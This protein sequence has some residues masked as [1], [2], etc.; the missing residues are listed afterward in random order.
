MGI[1]SR[2]FKGGQD[3]EPPDDDPEVDRIEAHAVEAV[4]VAPPSAPVAAPPAVKHAVGSEPTS[5]PKIEPGMW[6]WP[7]PI[8]T[9]PTPPVPRPEP[10]A[11][12]PEPKPETKKPPAAIVESTPKRRDPTTVSSPPPPIMVESAH[13]P[14][15][16]TIVMSPPPPAVATP[17]ASATP[18]APVTPAAP[19]TPQGR[20]P[21]PA[22]K[23]TKIDTINSAFDSM[24][25]PERTAAKPGVSTAA[26]L[27][28]VR[29]TFEQVAAVHVAHVRNIM[30]ELR[31]GEADVV[32]LEAARP[33]LQS[34]RKMA[35][36]MELAS[37]VAALDAFCA[38][39]DA[40]VAGRA[41]DAAGK[42]ELLRTYQRLVELVPQAFELDAEHDR[43]EPI[44]VEALLYQVDGVGLAKLDALLVANA[45]DLAAVTGFRPELASAIVAR[46]A[47]YRAAGGALSAVDVQSERKQLHD[48]VI[49]LSLQ[50]DNFRRA[51]AGWK[52][53]DKA[54]KRELRKEREHTF[55]QIKVVLARLGEREHVQRL[56]RLPFDDRVAMLD[57]L[58]ST[59]FA[60]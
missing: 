11:K 51:A 16:P 26:D 48:L 21:L 44:I 42:S 4:P 20:S 5:L 57:N 46:F 17:P 7:G 35:A 55:Q 12:P 52:D 56:D 36:Q 27:A 34:V 15:D 23:R 19:T 50:N 49:V 28:E 9:E 54:K 25:S 33:A 10:A 13:K 32:W 37:L 22:A 45:V 53:A 6:V 30:L 2:L 43:R 18:V 60:G 59:Q 1:F 41:L 38:A 3:G 47:I 39:L 14:R 8:R 31:F 29:R 24:I 58:I 40:R